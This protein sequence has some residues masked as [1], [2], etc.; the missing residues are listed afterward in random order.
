MIRLN[1]VVASDHLGS[2]FSWE[3]VPE[4]VLRYECFLGD[5]T[6]KIDNVDFSTHWGWVPV[7]DFALGLSSALDGWKSGKSGIFEFT[8]SEAFIRCSRSDHMVEVSASYSPGIARVPF[9][10]IRAVVRDFVDRLA[11][12]LRKEHPGL[13]SNI[14]FVAAVVRAGNE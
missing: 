2:D 5:V 1:A 9:E 14:E 6:F 4:W 11:D 8:E 13:K 12:R 3:T 7:L 10:E